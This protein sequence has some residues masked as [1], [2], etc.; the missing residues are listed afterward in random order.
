VCDGDPETGDHDCQLERIDRPVLTPAPSEKQERD[1]PTWDEVD[2]IRKG[3]SDIDLAERIWQLQRELA[4]LSDQ[5]QDVRDARDNAE[6]EAN[7][8]R[9]ATPAMTPN[10]EMVELARIVLRRSTRRPV[11]EGHGLASEVLRLSGAADN[12][13]DTVHDIPKFLRRGTD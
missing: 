10:P 3:K 9:S 8:L 4:E 13:S 6:R 11:F 12:R 7:A 2:A 5:L 1:S